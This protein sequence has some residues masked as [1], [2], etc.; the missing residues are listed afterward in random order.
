M[1]GALGAAPGEASSSSGAVSS[2]SSAV[3]SSSGEVSSSSGATSSS[4]GRTSSSSGP[5]SSSSDTE[6]HAMPSSAQSHPAGHSASSHRSTVATSY[7]GGAS[8]EIASLERVTV[9]WAISTTWA[10]I[11]RKRRTEASAPVS[12]WPIPHST[13]QPGSPGS[14]GSSKPASKNARSS[15]I[16]RSTSWSESLAVDSSAPAM[17]ACVKPSTRASQQALLLSQTRSSNPVS[18]RI[19]ID[20]PIWSPAASVT[21]S[22]DKPRVVSSHGT[23][24]KSSRPGWCTLIWTALGG[25]ATRSSREIENSAS[26]LGKNA[27][28][29]AGSTSQA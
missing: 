12:T 28:L 27:P 10:T 22:T 6:S 21:A 8:I 2:S 19:T 18:I 4:S 3:S 24:V 14:S 29:V 11:A 20:N 5:T 7:E 23:G 17:P 16:M 26:S 25:E 9:F 13:I 15:S 1:F